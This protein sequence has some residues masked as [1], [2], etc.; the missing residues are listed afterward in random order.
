MRKAKLRTKIIGLLAGFSILALV[1]NYFW[2]DYYL[3][4]QAQQEMLEK[5]SI[6]ARQ[7]ESSWEFIEINQK[8]ID[9]DS[10]GTYNFKGI[11]CA[12]AGKSIGKLFM[13]RTDYSIRYVNLLPR[14]ENAVADEFEKAAIGSFAQGYNEYYG[15]TSYGNAEV[16]RYVTPLYIKDSCLECHGSPAGEIDLTG[17]PKEGLAVGDIGGA[18]SIIMPIDIYLANIDGSIQQQTIFTFGV[19][20]VIMIIIYFAMNRLVTRPLSKLEGAVHQVREGDFSVEFD[21]IVQTDEIGVLAGHFRSMT[22]QLEEVYNGLEDQVKDRTQQLIEANHILEQ[23]R[24]QLEEANNLLKEESDYKSDFL[25]TMSH[26]LRTP[27]TSILAFTEVWQAKTPHDDREWMAV[28]EIHENGQLL[29]QMVNNIL[30]TARIDA[31][32][33]SLNPEAFDLA[34]LVRTVKS[35]IGFLANRKDIEFTSTIHKD[36]PLVFADAEKMRRIIENL[37]T[38][39]IKYTQRGGRVDLEVSYDKK[40]NEVVI[41]IS[42]N[43]MGIKEENLPYIFDRFVQ[44]DRSSYRRY[45]GSGLGLAVVKELVAAHHGFVE[46]E[47]ALKVGSVFRVRIPVAMTDWEQTDEAIV[48]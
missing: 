11:Y 34:D 3:H 2:S 18:L 27:L 35:T 15:M 21:D 31:G 37:T 44:I 26:E 38:N 42:D 46:V 36:V 7:M 19:T 28:Q 17:Y 9:T 16:F 47:S 14:N 48:D 5:T 22:K 33:H 1:A 6:L 32:R 25:A 23:Q 45:S 41:A 29:L 10:D 43:G 8:R 4:A 24:I 20:L 13:Q 40:R 39:A 30:E 12:I